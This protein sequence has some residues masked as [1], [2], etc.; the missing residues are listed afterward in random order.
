MV[1]SARQAAFSALVRVEENASYSNITLDSILSD[2][3]LSQRD[4]SFASGLF[5]GVIE[6]KLLLEIFVN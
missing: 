5:Y 6:K 4:K 3:S 1:N 2:S